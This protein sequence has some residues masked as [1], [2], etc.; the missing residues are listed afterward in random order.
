MEITNL[1]IH[2]AKRLL[3]RMRGLLGR[4]SLPDGEA[5]YIVPCRAIHTR[6]MQ[7]AIDA[8][9][10][11]KHGHLVK[12]VLNIQPGRWFV[13]G[14]WKAHGVLESRAGDSTFLELYQLPNH[15]EED[16]K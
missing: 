9:F 14:G 1:K 7:F 10:Y 8:R 6:R 3:Q 12:T 15:K 5:L 13:W 4:A 16:R 2:Y 11:D